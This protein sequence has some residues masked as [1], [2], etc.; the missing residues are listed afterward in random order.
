M[1]DD[2]DLDAAVADRIGEFVHQVGKG[3]PAELR[4]ASPHVRRPRARRR[5]AELDTLFEYLD[6]MGWRTPSR[7]T[8]RARLGYYTGDHEAVIMDDTST[9]GSIAAGGQHAA[10]RRRGARA[11]RSAATRAPSR[12]A[13][14]ARRSEP[15]CAPLGRGRPRRPP[16]AIRQPR[17]HVLGV[18]RA[19]AVRQRLDRRRARLHGDGGEDARGGRGRGLERAGARRVR[20]EE[21]AADQDGD[22]PSVGGGRRRSRRRR[23][24]R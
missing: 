11:P 8:S 16:R 12:A 22:L 14:S 24:P 4:S 9:V 7:S 3:S 10:A 1:V 21:H 15:R 20:L 13:A 2:K 5:A 19:D 18:G 6:A 23:T 17:G